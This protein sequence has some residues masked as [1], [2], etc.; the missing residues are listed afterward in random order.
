MS[1]AVSGYVRVMI[2]MRIRVVCTT[3]VRVDERMRLV[4]M[5]C[6]RVLFLH[7]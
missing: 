6:V 1:G 7:L 5:A 2:D 4:C 3:R